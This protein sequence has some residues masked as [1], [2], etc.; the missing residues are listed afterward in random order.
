MPK[1]I[2]PFEENT[3]SDLIIDFIQ[4]SMKQK[5]KGGF[6]KFY[7]Y[8][9]LTAVAMLFFTLLYC[10]FYFIYDKLLCGRNTAFK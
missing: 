2:V 6:K 1:V 5:S 4:L 7:N 8:A 10:F 3:L 9:V